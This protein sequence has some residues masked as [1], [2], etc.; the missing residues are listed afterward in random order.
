MNKA[1]LI[2]V[3]LHWHTFHRDTSA[4]DLTTKELVTHVESILM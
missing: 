4:Q 1:P 2:A 3:T